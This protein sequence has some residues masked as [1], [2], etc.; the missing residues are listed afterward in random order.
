VP[1]NFGELL[2]DLPERMGTD[3]GD[4]VSKAARISQCVTS[5]GSR[6]MLKDLCGDLRAFFSLDEALLAAIFHRFTLT[7]RCGRKYY[8]SILDLLMLN[9]HLGRSRSKEEKESS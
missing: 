5:F 9:S 8:P 3:A 7:E 2:S 1:V 4:F 6:L